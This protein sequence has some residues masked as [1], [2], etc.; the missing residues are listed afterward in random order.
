MTLVVFVA[1]AVTVAVVVDTLVPLGAKSGLGVRRGAARRAVAALRGPRPSQIPGQG[2]AVNV[3]EVPG[4]LVPEPRRETEP[5]GRG[6]AV[7]P[8]R[9]RRAWNGGP[10]RTSRPRRAA[11]K[12]SLS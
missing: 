9:G 5:A 11:A 7:T 12:A 10:A 3:G 2:Q 6:L 8:P 4:S 1:V